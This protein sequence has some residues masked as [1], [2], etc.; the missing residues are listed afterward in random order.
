V[1]S[2]P[3]ANQKMRKTIKRGSGDAGAAEDRGAGCNKRPQM[4]ASLPNF[5]DPMRVIQAQL[6]AAINP[7]QPLVAPVLHSGSGDDGSSSA[8]D[9]LDVDVSFAESCLS[10]SNSPIAFATG[11]MVTHSN[12]EDVL[13][14]CETYTCVGGTWYGGTHFEPCIKKKMTNGVRHSKSQVCTMHHKF[15]MCEMCSARAHEGC[16][17][18]SSSGYS[19]PKCDVP[20]KCLECTLKQVPKAPVSKTSIAET[21]AADVAKDS[22]C[23]ETKCLFTNKIDLQETLKSM[24]WRIRSGYPTRFYC[25]CAEGKCKT[26]F[27]AKCLDDITDGMWCTINMP[28]VHECA[29]SKLRVPLPVTSRVSN[30]PIVVYKDMQT[31]AC[32]K[33]FKPASI[34]QYIK[35][36]Y[37]IIV[38]TTLIYN[39]GYRAR[40]KLGIGDMEK[41]FSQQKV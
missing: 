7:T 37:G 1:L 17:V 10:T 3:K 5:P 24:K 20:W 22:D 32:C 39:V 15:V 41:I 12:G 14:T 18:P 29:G 6:L 40:S 9:P 26:R 30:L 25:E 31:L 38:D 16:H 21:S 4:T 28:A 23:A 36:R 11:P 33:S 19:L 34:Q 35:Q 27:S 2:V 13:I 8:S